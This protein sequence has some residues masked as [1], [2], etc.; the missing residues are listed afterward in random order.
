MKNIFRTGICQMPVSQDKEENI[1]IAYAM[2][3]KA[4]AKESRLVILPEMFNCPYSAEL[5]P[6]Y[7]E[8]YPHGPT[9]KMLSE[10]AR[11]EEIYLVGGV[12]S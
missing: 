9:I 11:E 3:K 5:F 7:A 8:S 10:A 2:I 1:T 6:D 12:Y 4:S